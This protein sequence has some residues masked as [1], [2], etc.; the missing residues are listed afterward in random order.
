MDK[1]EYMGIFPFPIRKRPKNTFSRNGLSFGHLDPDISSVKLEIEDH[2]N[3]LQILPEQKLKSETWLL[4]I[5]LASNITLKFASEAMLR[6]R[7]HP[8]KAADDW[9][10]SN[11]NNDPCPMNSGGRTLS[12]ETTKTTMALH[13]SLSRFA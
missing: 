8:N 4:P 6:W 2:F 12:G 3:V 10:H 13:Y 11:L 1:T 5:L 7:S 9:G